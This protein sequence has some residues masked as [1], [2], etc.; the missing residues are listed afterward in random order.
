MRIP[1]RD[2]SMLQIQKIS[3]WKSFWNVT[4]LVTMK[5]KAKAEKSTNELI[6]ID[7]KKITNKITLFTEAAV[8]CAM[9]FCLLL[10]FR[11]LL[12]F[13]STPVF[14]SVIVLVF[15]LIS[16]R[17]LEMVCPDNH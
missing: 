14:V 7:N 2:I 3:H 11:G 13:D 5:N 17:L 10:F 12:T 8:S 16:C 6:A 4:R 9:F 15:V 1:G